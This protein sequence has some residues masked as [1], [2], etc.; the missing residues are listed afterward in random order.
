[1]AAAKD[2]V[3]TIRELLAPARAQLLAAPFG[4]SPRE[5]LLLL[6][7]VLGWS[8]AQV[9]ARDTAEVPPQ[10]AATFATLLARR[11]RGEPVAYLLGR[12]E[13]WGRPF[14]VDDRV[15]VPRPETE[16]LVEAALAQPL[17]P[18]PHILDLGTG[19]GCLAV[20]L[21]LEIPG[22]RV[23]AVD[24]SPGALAVARRNAVALGAS[25]RLLGSDWAAAVAVGR[26]DLVVANPPYLDPMAP[27][28]PEVADWEPAGALWGGIDGL[29]VIGR[30][31]H[32]LAPLPP[33][34]PVLVEIG[35]GQLG[36]LGDLAAALGWQIADSRSDLAG[37]PRI[38]DLRRLG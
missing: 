36:A 28:G 10:A 4:P 23:I 11:L 38:V 9:L 18:L 1:V 21:A 16:H 12:R 15:L 17:P 22:S 19:S 34:T 8:E 35:A 31:L 30:M 27:P 29:E 24:R 2:A 25:V 26:F 32:S 6:G 3:T 20:T 5:A 33:A 13:F 37:I 7:A 14:A